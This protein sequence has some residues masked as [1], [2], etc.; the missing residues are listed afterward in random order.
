LGLAHEQNR[1]DTPES[2]DEAPQGDSGNIYLGP[3]DEASVMNYCAP[4]WLSNGEL[5]AGDRAWIR[6]AYFPE[7]FPAECVPFRVLGED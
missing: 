2:C 3:W 5:S 4:D 6:V 7:Y 1:R